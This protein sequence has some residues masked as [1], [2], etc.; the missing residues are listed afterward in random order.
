MDILL[1]IFLICLGLLLLWLA[2][3]LRI[4]LGEVSR[5][6]ILVLPALLY[7]LFSGS[8][9]K[10]AG[11]GLEATFQAIAEG[12]VVQVAL[13]SDLMQSDEAVNSPAFEQEFV[14]Q[15]C[16]PYYVLQ[17]GSFPSSNFTAEDEARVKTVARAVQRSLLCGTLRGLV[18]VDDGQHPKSFI[19][20]STL[21]ELLQVRLVAP[22][23][24]LVPGLT[25]LS[26]QAFADVITT[27]FGRVLTH[28][29]TAASHFG[30]LV[31]VQNSATIAQAFKSL[32]DARADVA[33]IIDGGGRFVGVVARSTIEQWVVGQLLSP[34]PA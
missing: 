23:S 4:G 33:M 6:A 14:R 13:A 32:I 27:Q 2:D 28:P 16:R 19:P 5:A 10:F 34:K 22:N 20:A 30:Q 11:F 17:N 21:S 31:V 26:T 7:L 12:P 8:I 3:R 1:T 25:P 18:L 29:D 15:E 9:Q 24:I